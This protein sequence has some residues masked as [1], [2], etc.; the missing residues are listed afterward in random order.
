MA[1]RPDLPHR[2]SQGSA[3]ERRTRWEPQGV[4]TIVT[5]KGS[6]RGFPTEC[7]RES[8][9]FAQPV[10]QRSYRTILP[11]RTFLLGFGIPMV[12]SPHGRGKSTEILSWLFSPFFSLS[13]PFLTL[14]PLSIPRISF[15]THWLSGSRFRDPRRRLH[16]SYLIWHTDVVEWCVWILTHTHTRTR[17]HRQMINIYPDPFL[18][19][20]FEG[21]KKRNEKKND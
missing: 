2:P 11:S 21:L 18:S 12:P 5:V 4:A 14:P 1:T 10:A 8:T 16:S 7:T 19:F 6:V 17:T 13:F 20:T 15:A 3:S 9:R